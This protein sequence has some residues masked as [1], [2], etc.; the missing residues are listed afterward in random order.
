M[1]RGTRITGK[2]SYNPK[3]LENFLFFTL[4]SLCC[5]RSH[6]PVFVLICADSLP[7][8]SATVRPSHLHCPEICLLS[9]AVRSSFFFHCPDMS[10]TRL[11]VQLASPE[12]TRRYVRPFSFSLAGHRVH[13]A[14]VQCNYSILWLPRRGCVT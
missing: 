7:R 1:D 12:Q 6:F 4:F 13:V 2:I 9:A 5:P 14:G 3:I 8:T 10:V 11:N